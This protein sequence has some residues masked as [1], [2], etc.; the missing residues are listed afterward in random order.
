[1]FAG[2][3]TLMVLAGLLA[4]GI[5]TCIVIVVRR[6]VTYSNNRRKTFQ[7]IQTH[8]N[9]NQTLKYNINT[10]NTDDSDDDTNNPSQSLI[11]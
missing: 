5:V 1:L 2:D 10:H 8:S 6:Y 4:L 7:L 11:K 3:Y 9:S